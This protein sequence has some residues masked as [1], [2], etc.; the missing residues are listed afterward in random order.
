MKT[1]KGIYR[2]LSPL[3]CYQF[4]H[5]VHN[6]IVSAWKLNQYNIGDGA[7]R[8]FPY[9]SAL[10]R[11]STCIS[12]E[13]RNKQNVNITQQSVPRG[14]PLRKELKSYYNN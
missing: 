13:G 8:A 5:K 14:L 10:M 1:G 7:L 4:A 6:V 11:M 9:Y 12:W 3:Q 2:N